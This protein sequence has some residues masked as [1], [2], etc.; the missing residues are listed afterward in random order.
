VRLAS[1]HDE[2]R[3]RGDLLDGA[4]RAIGEMEVFERVVAA[5]IDDLGA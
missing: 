5:A 2:Q 1:D 3:V 4:V